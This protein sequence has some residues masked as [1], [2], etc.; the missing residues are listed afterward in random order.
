M[1]SHIGGP[2][3]LTKFMSKMEEFNP[4]DE[5]SIEKCKSKAFE[6]FLAYMYMVGQVKV[7]ISFIGTI[8]KI[9]TWELTISS[10]SFRC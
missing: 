3:E 7:W 2:I 5:E 9:F 10:N 8:D 4:K 6:Q 1:E